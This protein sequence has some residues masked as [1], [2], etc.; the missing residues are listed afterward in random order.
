[1]SGANP[2]EGMTWNGKAWTLPDPVTG[3]PV[4][5]KFTIWQKSKLWERIFMV[6][7]AV[8]GVLMLAWIMPGGIL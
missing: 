1:M 3:E 4:A 2:Y 6:T 7:L 8:A 5:Q